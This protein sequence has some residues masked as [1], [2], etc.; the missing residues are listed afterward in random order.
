MELAAIVVK[1]CVAAVG[2]EN[3]FLGIKRTYFVTLRATKF[4]KGRNK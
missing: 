3:F 1:T 2:R 4:F